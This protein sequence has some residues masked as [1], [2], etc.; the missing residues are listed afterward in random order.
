MRKQSLTF[1][2][3]DLHDIMR[4]LV[5]INM[6][7]TCECSLETLLQRLQK[8]IDCYTCFSQT[9]YEASLKELTSEGLL[10][11]DDKSVKLTGK[12][13]ELSNQFKGL[14]FKKEPILEIVAGLT[15][16][17]I[18]GLIIILSALLGGLSKSTTIFAAALTLT[19]VSLTGFSSLLLGGKTEDIADL[20]SLN[21]LM[22]YGFHRMPSGE[23]RDKSLVIVK[24]LFAVLKKDI[25]RA[26]LVSAS[27]S[28]LTSML[29]GLIPILFLLEL[30]TPFG[31][32]FSL[33]F[34][35]VIILLF[36][37]RYRSKKTQVHWKVTLMETFAI[38]T[39]S[40]VISLLLGT[41]KI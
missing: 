30:P 3:S 22:E 32:V 23:E 2:A 16:G 37:V 41:L 40:V 10:T 20:I 27:I 7:K 1:E 14:L 18:T 34:V 6:G 17:S 36:L 31:A 8:F 15:D 13:T 28:G 24:N 25:S 39:V 19:A 5:L 35:A 33:A 29:S 38:I 4:V 11:Y 9:D 26:S 21:T 12:G